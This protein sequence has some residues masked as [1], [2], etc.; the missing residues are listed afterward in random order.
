MSTYLEILE[1]YWGYSSFRGIQ[2][3]IITSIGEGKD[4]LGLMP[5]GGGKSITFQVPALAKEGICL[6]VTPLIALMKD[7]VENLR[8]RGI[9]ATAVYSGMSRQEILT[10]FDNCIFGGYKFLYLSPERL[11]TDLFKE[12]VK[13]MPVNLIAVDESH[14]ISQWGYNFRPAYLKIANIKELLPKVPIL[15]LTATATPKVVIDIQEK[16]HFEK[17][18]LFK[19]SFERKN[20]AYLVHH[21]E[22]KIGAVLSLLKKLHGSAIVYARSRRRTR[23]YSRILSSEGISSTYFHAGL[24]NEHKDQRQKEWKSGKCRVIVATNAFGMGID[25]PDVRIVIHVDLPDSIE[26][27]FQEAGRAGRDLQNARSILLYSNSDRLKLRKRVKDNFPKKEYIKQ[28]YEHIQYYYQMAMGDGLGCILDF[29]LEEF[30]TKFKHFPVVVNSSL[31]LLTQAGYLEYTDEQDNPSRIIF[32]AHREELYKLREM[33]PDAEKLLQVLLRSYTG[34]FTDY[35]NISEE[36]LSIRSELDRQRIYELLLLFAR[37][38][39]VDYIPRKKT[40]FIIYTR[41]R[42]DHKQISLSKEVYD[43]RRDQYIKRIKAIIDYAVEKVHCRNRVLL[44]YFGETKESDCGQCDVCIKQRKAKLNDKAIETLFNQIAVLLKENNTIKIAELQAISSL[45]EDDFFKAI[46]YLVDE[47]R[48]NY[49][50]GE[51]SHTN[52]DLDKTKDT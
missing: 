25:K 17:Q 44:Q 18:N 12:K 22:D 15:A 24:N 26:A 8:S 40:P 29:N 46:R 14:C 9:K 37:R 1:K 36:T 32:K 7:Q 6:V 20:L 23:E 27:Y 51:L 13:R 34:L 5:T 19:M 30:C 11:D 41:E 38:G 2:E 43:D 42:I 45:E 31:N 21:T 35:A 10:T 49:S 39:I 28:V 4:T 52:F 33:G 47:E 50:L 48:V 3:D 16:L